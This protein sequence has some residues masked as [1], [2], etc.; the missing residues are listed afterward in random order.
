MVLILSNLLLEVIKRNLIVLNDTVD[1]ELLDTEADLNELRTTPDKTVHLNS[2]NVGLHLLNIGLIIP[3]LDVNGDNRL[4]SGLRALGSLLSG[5]LSKSLL[6]ELL[7]LL[8]DLIVV[9]AEE[10]NIIVILLSSGGTEVRSLGVLVTG[11]S[12]KL[13]RESINLGVPLS[14]LGVLLGIGLG[15]NSLED[16]NISLGGSRALN[17]GLVSKEGV[18]RLEAY[19]VRC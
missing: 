7:S 19:N 8:I 15:A 12:L 5:V 9:R 10:I 18:K 6:L 17:E 2:K 13:S 16:N 3:R 11:E 1:L 14:G 4:G